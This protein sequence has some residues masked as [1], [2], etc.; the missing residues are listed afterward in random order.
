MLDEKGN[1]FIVEAILAIVLLLFVF[2]IFNYTI[3]ISNPSYSGEIKNSKTA[4]D[5]MEILSGK[6]N[7][8]DGTFIGDISEILKENENSKESVSEVSKLSKD[9][10]STLKL[11]NYRFSETNILDGKVLA[12]SGDYSKATNVSVATRTYGDYSYTL[13][14]W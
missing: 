13:S 4:Q 5:T 8:T 1:F 7:F 6:I 9:K 10:F 3:S 12:G 2:L 14:I 11:E